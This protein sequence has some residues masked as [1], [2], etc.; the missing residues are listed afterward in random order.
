[1]VGPQKD[2]YIFKIKWGV[3]SLLNAG[4][5]SINTVSPF[6]AYQRRLVMCIW[7][8]RGGDTTIKTLAMAS[9]ESGP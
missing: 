7:V 1:M 8:E 4:G 6:T 5:L 9:Y 2:K 3:I